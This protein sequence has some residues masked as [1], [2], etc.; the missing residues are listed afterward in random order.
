MRRA[1]LALLAAAVLAP[2]AHARTTATRPVYDSKGRLVQTPFAPARRAPHLTEERATRIFLRDAKV[3]D[4]LERYP[5]EDRVTDATFDPKRGDWKVGVWWGTAGEIATGRVDDGT[6]VVTE[7]WTGPQVAWKM[8]RGYSGAFGGKKINTRRIWLAFCVV[9]L[10]GLGDLRRPLAAQPRPARAALVLG[11]ALVLQPRRRLHERAARLPA[12]RLPARRAWSGS[13]G[14]AAP[15]SSRRSG[16]SG[17]S[18][19]RRSSWPAFASGSTSATR[20]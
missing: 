4:W 10:L 19:R 3:A 11:L 12:A 16:R 20:T 2:A 5:N 18:R 7:A 17:C 15:G 8:A 9:F 1:A 14:A 6:G 13:S